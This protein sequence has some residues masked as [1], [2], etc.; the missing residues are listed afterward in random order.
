MNTEIRVTFEKKELID[1][2]R[3]EFAKLFPVIP[4]GYEVTGKM[5]YSDE[6]TIELEKIQVKEEVKV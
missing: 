4:Q 3:N 2:C 1:L 5:S 6:V